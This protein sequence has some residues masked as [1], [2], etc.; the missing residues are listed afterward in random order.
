MSD[1][2]DKGA[3]FAVDGFQALRSAR[4]MLRMRIV[5]LTPDLPK[6]AMC[7]RRSAQWARTVVPSDLF[8]AEVD[9]H[10]EVHIR[11]DS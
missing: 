8:C 6:M 4:I 5:S 7:F 1:E 10:G 9:F 3:L 11:H 2:N